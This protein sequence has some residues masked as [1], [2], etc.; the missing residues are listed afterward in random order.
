VFKS[1]K[2]RRVFEIFKEISNI[3]RGSSNMEKISDYCVEFAVRH[4]LDYIKDDASN[5]IIYKNASKGYENCEP[6]ILQGH[7]D[8]VCQ[9][10][11][12]SDIDFLN[13]GLSIYTDGDFLKARDT[14]LGADNGIAVAM[15]MAILESSELLH[16]PIEA[17]FTT[18]EEIGLLGATALDASVLKSKRMINIDSEEGN[19]VT[20]SCAGGIR[21]S[22]FLPYNK[23][24]LSGTKLTV[25]IEGLLGGHSGVEI[26]K[27][28]VNADL[29]M[30]RVLYS[31]KK[32]CD[33][34]ITSVSG[35]DKDNAIPNC[36]K[37][38]LVCDDC[39][40][41]ISNATDIL[42][43]IKAE[44]SSR[45]KDFSFSFIK[46]EKGDF[47]VIDEKAEDKLLFAL[48]T[49]PCSVM[50]MSAEIKGLVET[51]LN[52]GVLA[53]EDEKIVFHYALRS[54]KETA[55]SWLIARLEIF[56]S[57]IDCQTETS[58]YYPPWEFNQSSKLSK[59]YSKAYLETVGEPPLIKAIH[60]GLECAVFSKKIKG[61]DCISIGP[62]LFDVH[63]VNERLSV[64][65]T[66]RIF[67][68]LIKL[69]ENL[70]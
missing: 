32:R 20:V 39:D 59:L 48:N 53:T 66:Q 10:T 3:P 62:Q 43:V 7:L 2:H 70:E 6:I 61:L 4:N 19:T 58:G 8:M 50:E 42:N 55:L 67:E 54:N 64:S 15:I 13:Q 26:D 45:E 36:A 33:F 69:L 24:K 47:F 5:V 23:E 68:I 29:L 27:G 46:G 44:I 38:V 11:E 65:S 1:I 34:R 31:L 56:Y 14:S 18:D 49:T 63:T 51:S 21:F 30:A 60:A 37:A 41:V 25:C 57:V 12:S 35:G 9:K 40:I 28:R 22:A 16:P 17:V 52:L